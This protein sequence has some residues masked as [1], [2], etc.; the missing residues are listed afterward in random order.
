[1]RMWIWACSTCRHHHHLPPAAC[2]MTN[3]GLFSFSV[4]KWPSGQSRWRTMESMKRPRGA[5][6]APL[7]RRCSIQWEWQW[8]W[9][10]GAHQLLAL[11]PQDTPRTRS[12]E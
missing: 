3:C 9:Q 10:W 7:V 4:F 6:G 5:E 2:G 8:Q 11:T 1:V 12:D